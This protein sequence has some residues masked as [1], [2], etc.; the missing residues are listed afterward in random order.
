MRNNRKYGGAPKNAPQSDD[1]I[2]GRNP[3][4]EAL[5]S[6]RSIDKIF[7][8]DGINA[9]VIGRIRNLAKSRGVTYSF[10]DKRRL[11]RMTGG[12]NHQGVVAV[13]AA[14]AYS[15]VEDILDRAKENGE[16]PFIVICEG[17][18]DPHNLG[19]VIRTADAAG[20]HGVIIP[21]NRSVQL[22]S[23]VAKVAAGAIEH[24]P[25]AKVVNIAQTVEK[26]KKEGLWIVGTDL[27]ATMTH[28]ECDM[29]GAIGV[30]IGSEGEGISR[31]VRESCDFLVKI[32]IKGGAESLNASVAAGVVLYEALRQR[33]NVEIRD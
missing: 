19:A 15:S 21:K 7:I 24:I 26:L 17:L 33:S 20:C 3:V 2:Y 5:E 6:G 14:H 1:N 11:D 32:P 31:I 8:Q 27:S 10:T 30:V 29:A 25:V 12:E 28:Y 13:G 4:L 16:E 23:T 22:S 9:P 18:T